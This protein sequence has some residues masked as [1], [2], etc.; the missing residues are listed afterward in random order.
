MSDLRQLQQRRE[1]RSFAQWDGDVPSELVALSEVIVR[2]LIDRL[3]ELGPTPTREQVQQEVTRCVRQFNGLDRAWKHPWIC[4]I[5]REDIGEV[6][7]NLVVLCGFD[8]SEEWMDE[9]D[10]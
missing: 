9:R 7:W 5:E 2:Q 6:V 8:D 4:T 1:Q 3:I 10:W